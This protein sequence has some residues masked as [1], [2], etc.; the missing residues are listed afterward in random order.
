MG[1]E[2]VYKKEG[3][4]KARKE[5]NYQFMEQSWKEQRRCAEA[6]ENLLEQ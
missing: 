2:R 3:F 5:K 6:C 1:P 4:K